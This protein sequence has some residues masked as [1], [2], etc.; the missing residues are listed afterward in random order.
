MCVCECA[1]PSALW[2]RRVRGAHALLPVQIR[3]DGVSA[4]SAAAQS[5]LARRMQHTMMLA[6]VEV[7]RTVDMGRSDT[8]FSTVSHLGSIL[9]A[10]DSALGYDMTALVIPDDALD[11]LRSMRA[12]VHDVVL[13]RK[14]YP[15]RRRRNAARHWKLRRLDVQQAAERRV[16]AAR[17]A[18][19]EEAFMR[20]VEEDAHVRASVL[21]YKDPNYKP[22]S[23]GR[24]FTFTRPGATE[25]EE[26]EGDE[27]D[28]PEIGLDELLDEMTLGDG[29]GEEEEEE[30]EG[31]GG[32]AGGGGADEVDDGDI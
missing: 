27:E 29:G 28:F 20:D 24:A 15:R 13:V 31:G 6:N 8:T 14:H 3:R 4:P 7:A 30:G 2:K 19:D 26:D 5:R 9:H 18:R 22:G 21:L 32:G 23:G 25:E 10:G 12:S 11:V 16:E 1:D 17:R